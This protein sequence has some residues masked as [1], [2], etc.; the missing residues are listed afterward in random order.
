MLDSCNKNYVGA[1]FHK[2]ICV[3]FNF[4]DLGECWP[5]KM[6]RWLLLPGFFGKLTKLS[7]NS[8]SS[9]RASFFL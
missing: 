6:E 4:K 1:K 2:S 8:T 3:V 7:E 5:R 9:F